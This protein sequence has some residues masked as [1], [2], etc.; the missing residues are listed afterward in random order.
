MRNGGGET[1]RD[2]RGHM[3]GTDRDHSGGGKISV[4]EKRVTC[5]SATEIDDQR[6]ERKLV[7][8]ERAATRGIGR[9]REAR[10]L[11]MG[12]FDSERE[13]A[14]M[15]RTERHDADL[16]AEHFAMHAEGRT[17]RGN[18]VEG[19]AD[20]IEMQHLALADVGGGDGGGERMLDVARRDHARL[21]LHMAGDGDRGGLA[22]RDVHMHA[23]HVLLGHALGGIDG[24]ADGA[25]G[26]FDITD[27]TALD[28]TGG[29]G[30]D[31]AHTECGTVILAL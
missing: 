24:E 8:E 19:I 16:D 6:A 15:G 7:L 18:A 13:V 27:G 29:G 14:E 30:A 20:G 5:R 21:C 25:L 10:D 4:P 9:E 1:L 31:A 26:L 12:A 28:A 22:T 17:F 11:E 3:M 2:I 23:T